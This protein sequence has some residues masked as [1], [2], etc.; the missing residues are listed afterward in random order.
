MNINVIMRLAMAAGSEA[1]ENAIPTPMVVYGG[2]PGKPQTTDYVSEGV[3]GFGWVVVRATNTE[4]RRFLRLVREIE[5]AG[6][7]WSK[8]YNGGYAWYSHGSSQSMTRAEAYANAFAAFLR[9]HG[10]DAT[11]QSRM[12]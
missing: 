3:C 5:F 10:I 9:D 8:N 4:S 12:D 11:A 2:V 7:K 1:Y 6:S